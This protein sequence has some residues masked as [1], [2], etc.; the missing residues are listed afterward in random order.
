MMAT[1]QIVWGQPTPKQI[2]K[3]KPS[4]P[5]VQIDIPENEDEINACRIDLKFRDGDYAGFSL[6]KADGTKLRDCCGLPGA[7]NVEQIRYYRNGIEVYRETFGK[8]CRWLNNA[9][10]RWG[11]LNSDNKDNRIV[12]W[13]SI[14]PEETTAEMV[15][16][17]I[18]NDLRRYKLIALN[19]AEIQALGLNEPLTAELIKQTQNIDAGF[20]KLVQ[21]LK[22]P[23]NMKWGTFNG[24]SPALIPTG[25]YGLKFDLPVY[26]NANVV[27]IDPQDSKQSHQLYIGDMIKIG[28]A[29]KIVGLPSGATFGTEPNS[30]AEQ[31]IATSV[32]FPVQDGSDPNMSNMSND[33]SNLAQ[34]LEEAYNQLDQATDQNYVASCEKTVD[35]MLQLA[36]QSPQDEVEII[37]QAASLLIT[38]IQRG[39][40]PQGAAKLAALYEKYKGESNP[41][42]AALLRLRQIEGEYYAVTQQSPPPKRADLDQAQDKYDADLVAFVDEYPRTNSGAVALMYL[43]LNQEY[44]QDTEAAVNYYMNVAQNFANNSNGQ[45]AAGAIRR[46][47]STGKALTFPQWNYAESGPFG[48]IP[49]KKNVIFCWASWS[50]TEIN[51]M[52]RVLQKFN[53]IIVHGINFDNSPEEAKAFIKSQNLPWKNVC[54]AAGLEGIP[55]LELGV[56]NVPLIILIDETGKVVNPSILSVGELEL[57]LDSM[58]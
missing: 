45:K 38:A 55:A 49:G 14:S 16:A 36:A 15:L 7:E 30:E 23:Q 58:K 41:E 11:L 51:E 1:A 40:Y 37:S 22:I 8:E 50:P 28:D 29:W 33:Y 44:L 35:L 34:L 2:L 57:I 10:T 13:K 46:L 54:E 39:L 6:F 42:L 20:A 12:Q 27:V 53:N 5:E 18:N 25:K 24:S 9:G 52:I 19:E 3:Y 21:S 32:F 48:L 4:Q 47:Q 26:Y 31:V 56:Q 17:I 43:A